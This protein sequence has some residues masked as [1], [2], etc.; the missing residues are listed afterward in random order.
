MEPCDSTSP[1]DWSAVR[2]VGWIGLTGAP[3]SRCKAS[4]VRVACVSYVSLRTPKE[5]SC[6]VDSFLSAN[7]G[8]RI[9]TGVSDFALSIDVEAGQ[10]E[11]SRA[12]ELDLVAGKDVAV[13][14]WVVVD[15]TAAAEAAAAGGRE[16]G[17]DTD[18]V[19]LRVPFAR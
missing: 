11:V 9:M 18:L 3:S 8:S 17:P 5:S 14:D 13:G 16:R 4:S 7:T 19:L 10:G 15:W 2:L 6:R 12:L 1:G